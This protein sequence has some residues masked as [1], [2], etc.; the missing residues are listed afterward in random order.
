MK[1]R[2]FGICVAIAAVLKV[3]FVSAQ[4]LPLMPQDPAV[5][6]CV[7]PNGLSCY[8]VGNTTTKGLADITLVKRVYDGTDIIEAHKNVVLSSEVAVDSMLLNIMRKVEA[9]GIPADCAVIVSGDVNTGEIQ[10]KLKY[11][12]LM[13]NSSLPSSVPDYVWDG[14]AK[15]SSSVIDVDGKD[16][17]TVSY[18]WQAPR[19]PEESLHT[20]Q[21]AIYNKAAWELGNVACTWI[22]RA[23][24]KENIPYADISYSHDNSSDLLSHENFSF[25]VTVAAEDAKKVKDIIASVLASLDRGEAGVSDVIMAENSYLRSLEKVADRKVISND[26]YTAMCRNA[27]LFG[28]SLSSDRELLAFFRSKY[29]SPASRRKIFSDI[30]SAMIDMDVHADTIDGLPSGVML[31]DTIGLPGPFEAK[32]KI[33]MSKKDSFS[34]GNMWTFTNGLKVVYRKMNSTDGRLYYS[35]SLGSG[36]GN[37]PDLERGEG[38]YMSDYL[39][40]CWIAG[41]KGS[42]F[43][44]LLDLSG[45]TMETKMG[46]FNT[47][48]T[49]H[50]EDRNA[51]L[52][53]G[54]LLA[55]ANESRP[56]TLEM[57]YYSR[58]ERLK[59][60]LHFQHDVKA[61]IDSQM[62][63]GYKYSSYK[64]ALG[65]REETF[66]KA[67][68]LFSSMTSKMNDGLLV[69]VGDMDEM[70]LKRLLQYY[71]GGFKVKNVASRRPS[72]EYHPVSG[73]SAYNV[74]G[75]KDAAAVVITA[76]IAMTSANHFATEIVAVMIDRRLKNTFELKGIPVS[77]S[78]ARNI[79]PDERFSIMIELSGKSSVEDITTLYKILSDAEITAEEMTSCKEYLKKSY[80]LQSETAS[81]WL[82]VIP[83][84]H[85]EGKDFTT[86]AA[87]KIDAVTL[88]EL[89]N[90]LNALDKG[91]GIEYITTKK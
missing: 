64:S 60:D 38:A 77:L 73:W 32:T 76:P 50:V 57:D 44:D 3:G 66:V 52:L 65:V 7:F 48:I 84:R 4:E 90:V 6:S 5:Q 39:D 88:Q 15:V 74:E 70:E 1:V 49:G 14:C 59:L 75:E 85:Q 18:N 34:G 17:S 53:M 87:A 31:S 45:M 62:C 37:I 16:L 79:Y 12:S 61:A 89:Q 71:V 68:K 25:L 69:I 30:T 67:Q 81:Y 78:L 58:C 63:P 8:T 41:M 47:V 22:K 10:T 43:R 19:M 26:E 9:D 54:A 23:L 40:L 42:Y 80:A 46:L 72:L 36:F 29:V 33:R 35:M 20:T 91:A 55:V 86:G 21:L 11:M 83:L 56:D 28:T 2:L 82:R 24:R 27:F 51:K 13:V